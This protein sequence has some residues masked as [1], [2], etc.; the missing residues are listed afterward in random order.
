MPSAE[1]WRPTRKTSIVLRGFAA[2]YGGPAAA[3]L[4]E[5]SHAE[6]Q[7]TVRFASRATT[8]KLAPAHIDLFAPRQT[9]SGGWKEG[10]EVVVFHLSQERL[11]EAAEELVPSGR[12]EIVPKLKKRDRLFEEMARTVLHEFRNRENMSRL[13]MDSVGQVLAGHILR[14]HCETRS[15]KEFTGLLGDDQLL[16]LRRFI[17]EQIESGF[18]ASELAQATGLGPQQFIQKLRTTT[19]LSPWRYVQAYRISVAQRMLR[20][21]GVSLAEIS[22]RLGFA[23]QSHFTNVFRS[24]TGITPKAFRKLQ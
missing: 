14:R 12:F 2:L 9:H 7:V 24:K 19:G 6:A 20:N 22:N 10:W 15:R 5:H 11:E 1:I 17:D 18:S 13:Y 4:P 23:S 21:P 16:S 8:H 3:I